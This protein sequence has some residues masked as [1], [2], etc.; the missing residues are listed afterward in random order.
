MYRPPLLN[1]ANSSLFCDALKVLTSN[2]SNFI[3]CGDFNF[4]KIDWY[5]LHYSDIISKN[6]IDFCCDEGLSQLVESPTH[7]GGNILD[8]LLTPDEFLV[9]DLLVR[10][11]FSNS[12]HFSISFE[13]EFQNRDNSMPK[14]ERDFSNCG[15]LKYFLECIE[16]N[17][18]FSRCLCPADYWAEFTNVL[19]YGIE[20]FIS[21]VK[22]RCPKGFALSSASKNALHEKRKAFRHFN[23]TKNTFSKRIFRK[24]TKIAKT[25]VELDRKKYENKVA[26]STDSRIFHNYVKHSLKRNYKIPCLVDSHGVPVDEC[27]V[28][29]TLNTYF[30][31][32]FT[33]DDNN[34]PP[35]CQK[36]SKLLSHMVFDAKIVKKAINH[37]KNSYSSGPDGFPPIMIKKLGDA[38]VEPLCVIF[39]VFFETGF[40]PSEW[41]LANITPIYKGKGSKFSAANYRPI[42]LT[43]AF[44]KLMEFCIKEV[45]LSFLLDNHLLSK[46]QH[47]FLP[48]KSTLTE[49][50][51]SISDWFDCI[52]KQLCVDII[53]LDFCKAFDSVVHQKLLYKCSLYGICGCFLIFLKNFLTERYQR[54]HLDGKFSNWIKVKSGVPQGSVLGPILFLIYINDFPEVLDPSSRGKLFADDSKFYNSFFKCYSESLVLKNDLSNVLNWCSTWQMYLNCDKCAV[55]RFGGNSSESEPSPYEISSNALKFSTCF[56]DLG[57]L[58]SSDLSFSAHCSQIVKKASS[59]IGL[60]YRAFS[61]RDLDFMVKIFKSHVRPILEFNC[62]V[63][64]PYL[65]KDID[66]LENVQRSFT[67]RICGLYSVS[68]YERLYACNLEALELRRLKRDL[69]CTYK[70]VHNLSSLVFSDFFQLAPDVGTRGHHFKLYPKFARTTKVL[71]S[72]SYRVVNIWNSLPSEVV[73]SSN[74]NQFKSKLSFDHL[75]KFLKGRAFKDP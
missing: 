68:Y 11:P 72:F 63:W 67:K 42:S 20:N 30:A 51:E 26:R 22:K 45:L 24:W 34:L 8:L 19:N 46:C 38:L 54:V 9:S 35:M 31:S 21:T 55:M 47:G 17:A 50:L 39:T 2:L 48:D 15:D 16:W 7:E 4:P 74:L 33:V 14:F 29:D 62:E 36:T 6:F 52:D 59:K 5:T 43:S 25:L 41:K 61:S 28:P 13:V 73:S 3:I 23:R 56:R 69:F 44:C 65:L 58:I 53:L 18:I 10:E 37:L 60:I 12:D 66:L 49:L 75:S 71:N 1:E 57:I 32:V 27:D 64:N 40:L 70:I